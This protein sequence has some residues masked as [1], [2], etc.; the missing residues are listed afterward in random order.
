MEAKAAAFGDADFVMPF[1]AIGLETF[2]VEP[3]REKVAE[4]AHELVK[5]DYG[6]IV[7]SE[8]IAKIAGTIFE[9]AQKTSGTCILTV[10]FTTKSD[11][12]ATAGL[13]RA[14][15]LATGIDI[16]AND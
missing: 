3:I 16:L 2:A 7:V 8:N 4:I 10:P 15:K 11:G 6:L 9:E 5:G 1:S 12:F 14:I 13:G